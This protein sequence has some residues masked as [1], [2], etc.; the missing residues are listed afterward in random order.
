MKLEHLAEPRL[1]FA[2]GNHICPRRGI[3]Q[4]GVF[5]KTLR[6]RRS[7]INIGGVGTARCIEFLSAWLEK[8]SSSID[9]PE[10]AKQPNLRPA[11]SGF[12]LESGY[13][14]KFNFDSGLA[15]SILKSDIDDL[16]KIINQKERIEKAIELYYENVKFLAQNRH[17]DVIVCVVPDIYTNQ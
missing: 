11:F 5:D 16:L 17:V 13:A 6:N 1:I 8:C 14:A 2:N 9:G 4:Y 3:S 10:T 12:N 7:E 15:R